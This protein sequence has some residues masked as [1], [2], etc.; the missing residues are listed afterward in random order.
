[1]MPADRQELTYKMPVLQMP[2][3]KSI[4]LLI[5]V[6]VDL[7]DCQTSRA[8]FRFLKRRCKA[9]DVHTGTLSLPRKLRI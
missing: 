2:M 1:M 5:S 9:C 8:S 6:S 7:L 4:A 3:R